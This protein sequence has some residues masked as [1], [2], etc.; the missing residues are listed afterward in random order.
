MNAQTEWGEDWEKVE[1]PTKSHL[2]G[3]SVVAGPSSDSEDVVWASGTEGTVIRSADLGK[4]WQTYQIKGAEELDFRSIYAMDAN[5]AFVLSAGD[6]AKLYKTTDGGLN[7]TLVYQNEEKGVFFD[8]IQFTDSL[9]GMAYSDPINNQFL[10]I[11]TLDGGQTWNKID[12][13][14]MPTPIETEAGFAASGTG[15][16][17]RGEKVW[18]AMGNGPKSR[19]L[20]SP[21]FGETWSAH[22]TPMRTG[23]GMGIFSMTFLDDLKGVVVGGSYVDST[24]TVGNGAITLD[25]GKSWELCKTPPRGY[26]SCVAYN[27]AE[28]WAFAVG[29][30]GSDYSTDGGLNWYRI[31]DEGYYVCQFGAGYCWAVGRNGKIAKMQLVF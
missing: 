15:M 12:G 18:I 11:K 24:S 9:R 23:E 4:T 20:H 25:G 5:T 26:R 31:G 28:D 14:T 7:W 19:V 10:V 2:R 3:L 22:K 16:V 29:R 1:S 30:T 8:G 6:I 21:D 27:A 17:M 13:S